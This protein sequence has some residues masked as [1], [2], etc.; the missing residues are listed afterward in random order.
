M[1]NYEE[2]LNQLKEADSAAIR[3]Q[4]VVDGFD[5]RTYVESGEFHNQLISCCESL[6][7]DVKGDFPNYEMFPFRVRMDVENLDMYL[8][9]KKVQCMRPLA[10]VQMV[11]TSIDKMLKAPFDPSSFTSE[12]ANAYDLA[13]LKQNNGKAISSSSGDIYLKSLYTFLTP[14]RRFR[15]DYDQQSFAFDLARLYASGMDSTD[16]GRKFQFGPSRNIGKCVRILDKDGAEQ[17]LA[18]IRFYKTT[19]VD[20]VEI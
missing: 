3:M 15:K 7:V 5:I 20:E 6:S 12:L 8:D 16:D 17:Y 9:R 10:F 2:L 4:E 18:T 11:K 1:A 19:F 14:M 13:L